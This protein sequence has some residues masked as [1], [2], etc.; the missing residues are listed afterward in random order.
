MANKNPNKKIRKTE[1]EKKDALKKEVEGFDFE[2]LAKEYGLTEMQTRFCVYYVFFTNLNGPAAVELAGY[3]TGRDSTYVDYDEGKR[4]FYEK[5]VRSGKAK[6]LLGNPKVV[7]L[8]TK[9][10]EELNNQL[11]VDK[12]YVINGLKYAW[13]NQNDFPPNVRLQALIK[14][15]ETME[16]FKKVEVNVDEREDPAKLAR[17]AF[18]RR[19]QQA[20]ESPNVVE[21]K[22]EEAV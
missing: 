9:L 8:L 20:K 10:R 7:K 18:E 14:L 19:K 5:L 3:S 15:G 16:M 17:E 13:E 21:F 1:A 12:L 6:E 22:K 2:A 4:D 11:I